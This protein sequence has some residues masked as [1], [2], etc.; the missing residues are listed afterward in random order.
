[1][2]YMS[3]GNEL[4]AA[5][6]FSE[7]EAIFRK[8]VGA[9]P[10]SLGFHAQLALSLI[11][12]H[13]YREADS[14]LSR[15]LSQDPK[16]ISG[17]WYHSVSRFLEERYGEAIRSLEEVLPV[18]PLD[19][20]NF[21]TAHWMLAT[22]YQRRLRQDG[23]AFNEV[24]LMVEHFVIYLK[25]AGTSAADR[26]EVDRFLA[27]VKQQRPAENAGRW[28]IALP[29]VPGKTRADLPLQHD[30][31]NLMKNV[32]EKAFGRGCSNSIIANTEVTELP[33]AEGKWFERWTVNRCGEFV[34]YKVKFTPDR[35]PETGT[36]FQI[37]PEQRPLPKKD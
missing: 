22:S 4:I 25:A 12:Q 27:W 21:P 5:R 24:D 31:W 32:F 23:L 17:L 28:V 36:R 6:R 20:P 33:D 19:N 15:I 34:T 29:T 7:A 26:L 14:I 8:A 3:K 9:E 18:I 11:N 2:D 16:F 37:S 13:R 35:A 1:M 30:T 10:G